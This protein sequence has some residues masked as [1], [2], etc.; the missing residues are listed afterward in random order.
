MW[1]AP[2]G[3]RLHQLEIEVGLSADL[4]RRASGAVL[5][6]RPASISLRLRSLASGEARIYHPRLWPP[7]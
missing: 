1:L 4:E 3:L 2:G 7:Y 6:V 5:W